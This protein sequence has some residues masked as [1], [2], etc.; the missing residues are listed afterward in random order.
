FFYGVAVV[1]DVVIIRTYNPISFVPVMSFMP[2]IIIAIIFF[3]KLPQ[4][5][6][7]FRPKPFSH[8]AI[9]ALFYGV[10]AVTFYQALDSGASVSQL[11]PIS[12]ASIIV[13]VIL[14]ALFLNERKDIKKKIMSAVLVSIGV[15]LLA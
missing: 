3:K 5:K 2:G 4:M 8:V 1:N 11:S 15:L 9:Y 6:K 13:T 7:L 12:R 14:S 10:G